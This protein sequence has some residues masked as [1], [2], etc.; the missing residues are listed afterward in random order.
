MRHTYSTDNATD[1]GK[2][3]DGDSE[4]DDGDSAGGV[5]DSSGTAMTQ[6]LS[7]LLA[8]EGLARKCG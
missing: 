6:C 7:V 5:G 1:I 4:S 3:N 2:N 8:T